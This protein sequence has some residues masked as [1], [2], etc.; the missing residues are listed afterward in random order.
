VVE[1]ARLN[2]TQKS[3][4][5]STQDKLLHLSEVVETLNI[6]RQQT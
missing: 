3:V 4:L 1:N 6:E 5:R 2:T